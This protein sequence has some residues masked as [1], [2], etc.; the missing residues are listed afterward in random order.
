MNNNTC[1][2][3]D[4]DDADYDANYDDD[5]YDADDDVVVHNDDV[6]PPLMIIMMAGLYLMALMGKNLPVL[7]SSVLVM[8]KEG[9]LHRYQSFLVKIPLS[10]YSFSQ[11]SSSF[12]SSHWR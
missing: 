10:R 3:G 11:S 7:F 9:L 2:G 1:D 5:D 8:F 6:R 12:P 4:D